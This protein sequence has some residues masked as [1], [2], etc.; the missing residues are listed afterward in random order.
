MELL[1]QPLCR[2]LSTAE[3]VITLVAAN[4]KVMLN[5]PLDKIKDFQMKFIEY[6]ESEHSSIMHQ[7]DMGV[8]LDETFNKQIVDAAVKFRDEYLA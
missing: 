8:G 7:I 4:A 2:P 1:K 5:I 6:M 3:Q